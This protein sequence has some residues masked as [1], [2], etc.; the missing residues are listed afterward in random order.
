MTGAGQGGSLGPELF[1]SASQ[2]QHHVEKAMPV[3][4]TGVRIEV[5]P[6][7]WFLRIR[8]RREVSDEAR[9][10]ALRFAEVLNSYATRDPEFRRARQVRSVPQ[11]A[12][13]IVRD[14]A[15]LSALAGVGPAYTLQGALLEYVGSAL[16]R[17][18][19]E[20]RASCG[21]DH[22]VLARRKGRLALPGVRNLALVVP[23]KVGAIG[24]HTAIRPSARRDGGADILAV[25]AESCILA[26]AGGAAATA[27]IA[28]RSLGAALDLLQEMPGIYGAIVVGGDQIGLAGNLQ[29]VA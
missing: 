27:T 18:L 9:V 13:P 19:K 5:G 21:G 24:I 29:L 6:D 12:P 25:V 26:D 14:M 1:A 23:R 3:R 16:A 4:E 11:D 28:R 10:A 8:A 2:R 20:V 22:F 15:R 17:Q 7:A